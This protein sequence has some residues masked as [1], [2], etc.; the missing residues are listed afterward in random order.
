M[1]E[2]IKTM[3]S[4]MDIS[5]YAGEMRDS[6][7]FRVIY[8]ALGRWCLES[9]RPEGGIS[10][11]GQTT[12]LN[13]LTEKYVE[14]FPEIKEMLVTERQNPISVFIR[15]LYEETG[16]LITNSKNYNSLANYCRGIQIGSNQLLYGLSR[17]TRME[18]LGVF[19]KDVK[20]V[21]DWREVLL[22]DT[23]SPEEYLSFAF[24]VAMF[25]PRDI[26]E[27]KIQYFNPKTNIAP[28]SSWI[29]TMTTEKTIARNLENG[30]Y[31]RVMNYNGEL[32]Y[33][34]DFSGAGTDEL[35]G[36]EYRRLYYALKKH[37]GYPLKLQI[38]SLDEQYSRIFLGGHLPNREY[39]LMLL[40]S[41]PCRMYDNK[42]E[43]IIKKENL[44]FVGEVLKN[45][46]IEL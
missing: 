9:A 11:K 30:T 44:Y 23:L 10:K 26:E 18:G 5:P 39:Y 12:L 6:F 37:Y 22:R 13:N 42:C 27:S 45:I 2:L 46:G 1:N 7:V 24:D 15:R 8:S 32:L 21:V 4:D 36:Y 34:N 14:L 20:Y 38:Q 31:Y 25:S 16:Y 41:W 3:A 40:C 35:T 33:C 29:D 43:F 19:S 28:S 17:I